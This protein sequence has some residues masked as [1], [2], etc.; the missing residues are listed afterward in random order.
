MYLIHISCMIFN[1]VY[2]KAADERVRTNRI[3]IFHKT[4]RGSHYIKQSNLRVF[5]FKSKMA[6]VHIVLHEPRAHLQY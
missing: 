4:V 6:I 2:S 1:N 5:F 3:N